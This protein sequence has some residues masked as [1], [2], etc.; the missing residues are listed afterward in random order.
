MCLKKKKT[1]KIS[2]K[3]TLG[4]VLEYATSTKVLSKIAVLDET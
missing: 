4:V 1:N 2:I 3:T